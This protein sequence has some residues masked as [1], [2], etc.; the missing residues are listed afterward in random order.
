MIRRT[1]RRQGVSADCLPTLEGWGDFLEAID[2][3]VAELES[4]RDQSAQ[5]VEIAPSELKHTSS[6]LENKAL[7]RPEDS[8]FQKRKLELLVNERTNELESARAT[9]EETNRRLEYDANNDS[10]T[11]ARNR[12]YLMRLLDHDLGNRGNAEYAENAENGELKLALFFIDL[13][14]FKQVNDSLGHNS[15]DKILKQMVDR[16]AQV[17]PNEGDCLAR[18]GGDEFAV[19]TNVRDEQEAF[20]VAEKVH[21]VISNPVQG[22]GREIKLCANVGFVIAT[23]DY[24]QACDLVRDSEIAM[25]KAKECGTPYRLFDEE[26]RRT[27]LEQIEIEQELE[28]AIEKSQFVVNYQ[29]IIDVETKTVCS[30]ESLVRWIHPTKGVI[31]PAQFIP[32][33]EDRRLVTFIDR[34]VFRKSCQQY[35]NWRQSHATFPNQKFNVNLASEQF[36]R[37]DLVPFLTE[38]L[39]ETAI[40]TTDVILEI[41]ENHLL[42]DSKLVEENLSK[43]S[44]IGF[45]IYMDDFGTGYS[46]LNYLA[47]YPIDG[48]KIDRCFVNDI[49]NE[50][51]IRELLKSILAMANALK[52][53]VVTEGVET[54]EQLQILT[55]LGC[56][57]FQ[58]YLFAKPMSADSAT[59]FLLRKTI[60]F[61]RCLDLNIP[62]VVVP[63]I[64]A[65]SSEVS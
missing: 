65:S 57:C 8:D 43:L 4:N 2:Q 31:S 46:S 39:K 49:E 23:E 60:P 52:I 14:R 13:D 17:L 26:M 55:S 42:N 28:I 38:T 50:P 33:A 7:L 45:M 37:L 11:G 22:Y 54:I 18:V 48:I 25:Y 6:A 62:T 34:I 59:E 56:H 21:K 47:K 16:I 20:S 12:S 3:A 36:D 30:M 53:N 64:N 41:T 10:L 40:E 19:L 35:K 61:L 63:K 32:L 44:K 27:R 9:L 1:M 15:G 58:G 51:E 24:T 5:S 29:P